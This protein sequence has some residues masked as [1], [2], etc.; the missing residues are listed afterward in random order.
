MSAR[1]AAVLAELRKEYAKIGE[2]IA[3]LER[4]DGDTPEPEV[5][6]KPRGGGRK[7][8]AKTTST[9]S[10]DDTPLKRKFNITCKKCGEKYIGAGPNAACPACHPRNV[11]AREHYAEK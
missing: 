1:F 7:R 9:Q 8:L 10:A 6:T 5:P 4:I 2:A 3:V 11:T